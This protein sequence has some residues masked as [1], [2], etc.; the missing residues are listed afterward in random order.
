MNHVPVALK[1]TIKPKSEK[2]ITSPNCLI[3]INGKTTFY[4]KSCVFANVC[5][6]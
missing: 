4:A 3:L 6:N 2:S 5:N 1:A